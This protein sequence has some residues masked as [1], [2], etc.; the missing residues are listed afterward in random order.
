MG[1]DVVMALGPSAT[2]NSG[3]PGYGGGVGVEKD[4]LGPLSSW[5]GDHLDRDTG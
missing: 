5:M 3:A 4:C 1:Q 2:I